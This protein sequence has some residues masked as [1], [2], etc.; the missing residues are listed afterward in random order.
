MKHNSYNKNGFGVEKWTNGD[1]FQGIFMNGVKEG[2]G[3]F[4]WINGAHYVG[5]F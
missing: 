5:K 3:E 1:I 2:E 4:K